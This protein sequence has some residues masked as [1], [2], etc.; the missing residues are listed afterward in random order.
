MLDNKFDLLLSSSKKVTIVGYF[1]ASNYGDDLILLGL[2]NILKSYNI[3]FNII[4]HGYIDGIDHNHQCF[5]WENNNKKHNFT[6]FN[7]A[8]KDSDTV[9]WGGGTCFTDEEGDGL[10]K[11][12]M[13]LKIFT[14]IRI[15][16]ISVGIG[17][18]KK[19]R[20][21]IKTFLIINIANYLS[22]REGKSYSKALSYRI[23]RKQN[24][25]KVDD[26]ARDIIVN[27]KLNITKPKNQLLIAWRDLRAYQDLVVVENVVNWCVKFCYKKD[28]RKVLIINTDSSVDE[29]IGKRI[30]DYLSVVL[31]DIEIE[32]NLTK[33]VK[34][35]MELVQESQ[36]ILTSRLHIAM[37]AENFNNNECYIYNYSPKVKYFVEDASNNN[38][39]LLEREDIIKGEN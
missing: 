9:I 39:I 27:S 3:N 7:Q 30:K 1:G 25:V 32:H 15:A 35:K 18:L 16:Y 36:Y 21:K 13:Y 38:V 10:F 17:N 20:S 19:F 28:I 4:A 8:T 22:F 37:T 29:E 12:M 33:N 34:E 11:Y 23:H 6:M 2:I 5:Y 14:S 24:I 31:T 26:L